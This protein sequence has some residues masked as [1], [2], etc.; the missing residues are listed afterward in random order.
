MEVIMRLPGTEGKEGE[1]YLRDP[2]GILCFPY[3]LSRVIFQSSL[4]KTYSFDDFPG[5]SINFNENQGPSNVVP[6]PPR[7]Q[8]ND[9]MSF[10][11][12]KSNVVLR[13]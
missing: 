5:L 2:C 9:D 3:D 6:A 13:Q 7:P 8:L 4:K 10:I 1:E 11:C 12:L